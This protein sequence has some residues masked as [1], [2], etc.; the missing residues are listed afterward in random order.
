M[1]AMRCVAMKKQFPIISFEHASFQYEGQSQ[2][3]LKDVKL[4]IKLGEFLVITGQSGCGKTTLTRCINNLIPRFFE[5]RLSGEVIVLGRSIK[6]S[7]A[8]EAGKEIASIFQDPRS[9][10]FTTNSSS[11]VAFACENYGI[12]HKEI[13]KRVN[14][15]FQS[16]NMENLKDRDIF[17]LSSGER[18]KVAFLAATTLNP[19]IYVLDEPSANLDI[20]TILQVREILSAL[21]AAGHTIIVSEHRLFYLYGLADRFL[22]M[23]DGQI[24]EE[25]TGEEMAELSA[26]QMHN[27]RLRPLNLDLI[28][29]ERKESICRSEVFLQT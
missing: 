7:D 3:S 1:E 5:G 25:L 23:E 29:I 12:P 28:Q 8:G 4:I 26:V 14:S 16:L 2:E 13:V 19:Q 15:A 27:R 22:I 21:K 24:C 10:F 9:Q 18:Q 6:E 20:H 11:E 17:A